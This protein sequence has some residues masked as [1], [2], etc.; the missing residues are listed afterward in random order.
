M[1]IGA[2]QELLED[3]D[4]QI[5]R[6]IRL[7]D[8]LLEVS[9]MSGGQIVLNREEMDLVDLVRKTVRHFSTQLDQSHCRLEIE[10][11]AP[12]R[13]FWDSIGLEEVVVNLLSNAMKFGNGKPIRI[14]LWQSQDTAFFSI[15]DQGIGIPARGREKIFERFG[16]AVSLREYGGLGVGLYVAHQIV[17]AHGGRIH[18]MSEPGRGSTFTVEVPL[19]LKGN[20][21]A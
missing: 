8:S 11:E 5:V 20:A 3:S 16:R 17:L 14:R 13:G 2:F 10:A 1:D 21:A 7:I 12:V 19:G 15:Q 6:L 9:R 4:R 18:L